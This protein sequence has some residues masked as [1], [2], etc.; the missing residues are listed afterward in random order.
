MHSLRAE[1]FGGERCGHRRVDAAGDADHHVGEAV[2]LHVVSQSELEREAHLLELRLEAGHCTVGSAA[3]RAGGTRVGHVD[4][5]HR[6]SRLA[7]ARQRAPAHVA[8]PPADD[9]LRLDVHEEQLLLEPRRPR[10][11]RAFVVE[12]ARVA[13]EDQL[14]LPADRVAEGDEARI[15]AG[16]RDEHLLALDLLADMERR[17]ADVHE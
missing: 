6:R 12:H 1:G 9:G 2:L 8:Q 3:V 15:V 14:V 17:G 16:A 10:N 13:V 5:L 4:D 11:Y 7:L